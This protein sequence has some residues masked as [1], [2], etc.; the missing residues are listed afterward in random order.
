MTELISRTN[1][2]ID[3]Y[4]HRRETLSHELQNVEATRRAM[5]VKLEKKGKEELLKLQQKWKRDECK[6]LSSIAKLKAV[7]LKKQAAQA[8]E[9]ELR[10]IV[11]EYKDELRRKRE[12][13]ELDLKTA[14]E[15]LKVKNSE[16]FAKMKREMDAE[17][18]NVMKNI[19]EDHER[20][21]KEIKI[22]HERKIE[23]TH[24]RV[25][26]ELQSI[27]E[28]HKALMQEREAIFKEKIEHQQNVNS[29]QIREVEL[30]FEIEISELQKKGNEEENIALENQHV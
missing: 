22:E 26:D 11:Q 18:R 27:E 9:P 19:D 20:K 1:S 21:S 6:R 30:A 23:E 7:D 3:I 13:I 14:K 28:S 4:K 12:E 5:Y 15:E 2:D 10:K 25:A 17:E 16:R 29:N 24:K 8:L